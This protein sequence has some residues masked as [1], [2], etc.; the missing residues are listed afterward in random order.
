LAT[1]TLKEKLKFRHFEKT[2][3]PPFGE[4]FPQK[5][6]WSGGRW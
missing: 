3:K 2:K 1:K 4:I 6:P 5:K